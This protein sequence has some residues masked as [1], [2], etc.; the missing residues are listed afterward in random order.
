M[1]S[2]IRRLS[3]LVQPLV[4]PGRLLIP[5]TREQSRLYTTRQRTGRVSTPTS[6]ADDSRPPQIVQYP[7]FVPRNTRGSLPVYTDVRNAG[8]RYMV[9]I[10]NIEGNADVSWTFKLAFC[11]RY[12]GLVTD[13]LPFESRNAKGSRKRPYVHSIS[14]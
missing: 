12:H 13:F 14:Q 4:V 6:S 10:R 7:Y 11:W 8:G 1:Q 9:L 2:P 5:N 3:S